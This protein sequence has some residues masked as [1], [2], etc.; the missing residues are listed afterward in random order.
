MLPC[1][2]LRSTPLSDKNIIFS[3]FNIKNLYVL[4]FLM[5]TYYKRTL[6]V[7]SFALARQCLE[8]VFKLAEMF[9][10]DYILTM[11]L[12]ILFSTSCFSKLVSFTFYLVHSLSTWFTHSFIFP[13]YKLGTIPTHLTSGGNPDS[14]PSICGYFVVI[15]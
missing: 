1:G 3:S 9:L 15:H 8:K 11:I 6:V 14:S 12:Y 10:I 4:C 13:L 2:L 7:S 5:Y